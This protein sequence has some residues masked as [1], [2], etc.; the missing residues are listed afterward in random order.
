MLVICVQEMCHVWVW[1]KANIF[2]YNAG[3]MRCWNSYQG[4]IRK[5]YKVTNQNRKSSKIFSLKPWCQN[6]QGLVLQQTAIAGFP[7]NCR[8]IQNSE[9]LSWNF[10]TKDLQSREPLKQQTLSRGVTIH[11][12]FS[13]NRLKILTMH[14][15]RSWN[16]FKF[17]SLISVDNPC[18]M[19]RI[20]LIAIL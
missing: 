17:E 1:I 15:C 3:C 18:K 9:I 7:P 4:D 12:F 20:G 19:L 8:H 13:M 10:V 11:P 2:H 5:L 16:F 6:D 14:M